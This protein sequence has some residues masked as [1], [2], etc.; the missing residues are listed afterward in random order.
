MLLNIFL[1]ILAVNFVGVT[2]LVYGLFTKVEAYEDECGFHE[3]NDP[4]GRR[5]LGGLGKEGAA[6]SIRL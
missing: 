6:S 1:G 2:I 5:A 3:G 4:R